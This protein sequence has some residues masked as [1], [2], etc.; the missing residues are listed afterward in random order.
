M[1]P[2]NSLEILISTAV[3]LVASL[4]VFHVYRSTGGAALSDYELTVQTSRADGLKPGADVRINGIKV[5]SIADITLDKYAAVLRLRVQDEIKIPADSQVAVSA[6]GFNPGS[7]LA[8]RP[9][10]SATPL[11]PGARF[12]TPAP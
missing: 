3:L 5:G 6:D 8:I 12:G 7:Y 9:G 11:A 4:F 2:N 10:K 1:K